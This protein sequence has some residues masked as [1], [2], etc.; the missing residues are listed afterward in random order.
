MIEASAYTIL[1]VDDDE[2]GRYAKSRILKRAGY[3][4]IESDKGADT[5]KLVLSERPQLVLLDVMLPDMNGLDVCRSLKH[6]PSTAHIMILQVSATHVS[7][8]DRIQG[9]EG[10]ADGYLTEPMEAEE[11]LATVKALLRLY[12]REEENRRLL[13]Q[14]RDADRRK[15]EFLA[16]LS[17][18]L[19]N[20]LYPIRAAV[21]IMRL[22]DD[23]DPDIQFSRDVIDQQVNHL[24]RLIDDL[25]DVARITRDKIELR[26]GKLRLVDV[27]NGALASSRTVIEAHGH[28]P[29]VALP[30][31]SVWIDGDTV[32]LTQIFVN[33]LSNAAKYTP[34]GGN[35][36]LSAH[37]EN[38]KAIVSVKDDGI[39]IASDQLPHV[40]EMFYQADG[41]LERS[42]AGLG[43]GLTLTRRLVELHG[44]TIEA[45]SDGPAKAASF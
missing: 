22:K 16:T 26:R 11:L 7:D 43:I 18:E 19:R 4:V 15:N 33:L 38:D 21:E 1:N 28:S 29:T 24:T 14:L 5:L 42:Q 40:F 3:N 17:H 13:D 10:G 44:G 31:E 9:L 37:A 45:R 35:I 32:R 23:L 6:D 30:A 34:K 20:P 27:L 12:Q 36:W 25:L 8:A 41:S 2:A 39:G